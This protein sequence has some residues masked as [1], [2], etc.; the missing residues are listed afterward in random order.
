MYHAPG[1]FKA[2]NTAVQ[3]I[4]R[5]RYPFRFNL[6]PTA[7]PTN[8]GIMFFNMLTTALALFLTA[9]ITPT[10]AGPAAALPRSAA[11]SVQVTPHD[12][13]SSS[14][15]VLGCK[16]DP[17]RIAYFPSF[18]SCASL[19]KRVSH[20][21]RSL[22]LLHADTSGGAYDISYDAFVQ[23]VTGQSARVNP[24]AADPTVMEVE[25]VPTG[26]PACRALLP[27]GRLP[28]MAS[29][30]NWALGCPGWEGLVEF[31]NVMDTQCRWGRFEICGFDGNVP[32]CPSGMANPTWVIPPD[33]HVKNI[34]YMTG[35]ENPAL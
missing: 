5:Q 19:C 25:D 4:Q 7:Y 30:P 23:L 21:G 13:Y 28:M 33:Q 18:P 9:A 1:R 2:R 31:W 10:A 34:E 29:S 35:K 24:I 20:A 8:T 32:S 22:V 17:N 27:G 6:I 11:A 16:V 26:D 14:I 3:Q 15:G 12:S